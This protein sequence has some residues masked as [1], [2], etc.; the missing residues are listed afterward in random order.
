MES[1]LGIDTEAHTF[2][3]SVNKSI[4]GEKEREK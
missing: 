2:L 4:G 3:E 1:I